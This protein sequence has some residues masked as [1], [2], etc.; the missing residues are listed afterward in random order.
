MTPTACTGNKKG[1]ESPRP[2]VRI[3]LT[4]QQKNEAGLVQSVV[5]GF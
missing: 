4:W 3:F 1:G 2:K 5:I